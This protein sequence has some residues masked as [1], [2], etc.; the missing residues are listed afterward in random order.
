MK[1][2]EFSLQMGTV[3]A[4]VLVAVCFPLYGRAAPSINIGSGQP[5]LKI[6]YKGTNQF[7]IYLDEP[8]TVGPGLKGGLDK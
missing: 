3:I 7:V 8:W 2:G 5:G 4:L 1:A 6:M